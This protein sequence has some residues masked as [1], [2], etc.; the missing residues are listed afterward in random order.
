MESYQLKFICHISHV[1]ANKELASYYSAKQ[2][3]PIS[4]GTLQNG[5]S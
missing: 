4:D 2:T 5:I 3:W 1:K